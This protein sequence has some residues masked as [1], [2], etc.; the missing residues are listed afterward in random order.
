MKI[1]AIVL[2]VAAVYVQTAM[3]QPA[4]PAPA[5]K[6]ELSP[7]QPVPVQDL[8][9]MSTQELRDFIQNALAKRFNLERQQVE[10]E[11]R[12][13]LLFDPARI[14]EAVKQLN[15]GPKN[16]FADNAERIVKAFAAVDARYGKAVEQLARKECAPAAE[17]LKGLISVRDTGYFA[18]AKQLAYADAL[19]A[20]G[21][22]QEAADAYID[23]AKGQTSC[24]SLVSQALLRAGQVYEGMHRF[25]HA[26]SIYRLWVEHFGLLDSAAADELTR[27]A[28]K[29]AE[30]YKDPMG[31]LAGMMGEVEKALA[32]AQ[33]GDKTQARQKDIVAMLDDLIA[34]EEEKNQSGGQGQGQGQGA[35]P[36]CGKQGCKGECQGG[37]Q[38]QA[39]GQGQGPAQ[40]LGVPSSPATISQ[41]PGGPTLKPQGLSEIRPSDPTDDWGKLSPRQQQRLL[42]QFRE[43][44]P[45]RYRDMLRD[46]YRRLSAEPTK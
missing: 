35:C 19:A 4:A 42:E 13:G 11:I 12:E 28:D 34:N 33:S 38:A 5:P 21:Q 16:T 37:G 9:K 23:L 25:H 30:D 46:Y 24:F 41:L 32:A 26:M 27:R 40:G 22:S 36:K 18:A 43:S 15:A 14:D 1:T 2:A 39:Q 45:E 7:P 8:Q 29:I 6:P 3:A 17:A 44:M 31:T 20:A 10:A